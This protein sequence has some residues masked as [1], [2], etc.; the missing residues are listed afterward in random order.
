MAKMDGR[1]IL[2]QGNRK[3]ISIFLKR[4]AVALVKALNLCINNR[5][6][7]TSVTCRLVILFWIIWGVR[8]LVVLF[9]S[10]T[11]SQIAPYINICIICFVFLLLMQHV[12]FNI[13]FDLTRWLKEQTN[14]RRKNEYGEKWKE[15]ELNVKTGYK[16]AIIC[17]RVTMILFEQKKFV[18]Q[19]FFRVKW[20]R[21]RWFAQSKSRSAWVLRFLKLFDF[22]SPEWDWWKYLIWRE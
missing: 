2:Q 15:V 19:F 7:K 11:L 21:I 9:A 4:T 13:S 16:E 5:E 12:Q 6:K 8:L 10:K 14:R 3:Y 1:E 20:P 17:D 22:N 18:L